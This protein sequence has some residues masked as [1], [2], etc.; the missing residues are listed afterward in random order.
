MVLQRVTH[1]TAILGQWLGQK[2]LSTR[3]N[4]PG[5]RAESLQVLPSPVQRT[6]LLVEMVIKQNVCGASEEAFTSC[7]AMEALHCD[8]RQQAPRQALTV[9]QQANRTIA[10]ELFA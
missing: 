5:V 1:K 9:N 7:A 8:S 4:P 3:N 6:Q 2:G 10:I